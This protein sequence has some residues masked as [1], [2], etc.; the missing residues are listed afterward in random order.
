MFTCWNISHS[1]GHSLS[2]VIITLKPQEYNACV[3]GVSCTVWDWEKGVL[4]CLKGCE[5][6]YASVTEASKGSAEGQQ[7]DKHKQWLILAPLCWQPQMEKAYY[8]EGVFN[9]GTTKMQMSMF[10]SSNGTCQIIIFEWHRT[11]KCKCGTPFPVQEK[12]SPLAK[13][14]FTLTATSDVYTY[15]MHSKLSMMIE[16]LYNLQTYYTTMKYPV[17]LYSNLR[18]TSDFLYLI[19]NLIRCFVLIKNV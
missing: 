8:T 15:E 10:I 16:I 18:A 14:L 19:S 17:K 1:V 11:V 6:C 2:D 7:F 9:F 3:P 12:R 4:F 5:R 13:I